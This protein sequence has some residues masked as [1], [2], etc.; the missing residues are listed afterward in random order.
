MEWTIGGFEVKW[1]KRIEESDI[2][3]LERCAEDLKDKLCF[4]VVLY[5]GREIAPL[6]QK[7]VALPFPV[8]FGIEV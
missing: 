2:R 8:F 6:S 7:I 1:A 4:S 3:N 5:G